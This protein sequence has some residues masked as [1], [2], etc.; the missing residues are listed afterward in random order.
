[1]VKQLLPTASDSGELAEALGKLVF[2]LLWKLLFHNTEHPYVGLGFLAC[3]HVAT[4]AF[5]LHFA[6][7]G[8][9]VAQRWAWV[10][11]GVWVLAIDVP[12]LIAR[13]R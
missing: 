8:R 7:R 1:M 9:T 10:L 3:L 2:R 4:I 6:R 12:L 5:A 11:L 13:L